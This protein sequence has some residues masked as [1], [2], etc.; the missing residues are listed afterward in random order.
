MN[1][2]RCIATLGVL[3]VVVTA[4][5]AQAIVAPI[6][7]EQSSRHSY[8]IRGSHLLLKKEAEVV[9]YL[10]Q[11]PEE[12]RNQALKKL[13]AFNFTVGSTHTWYTVDYTTLNN[14]Q[15]SS[16]CRAVGTNCYIFVE[17][18]SWTGGKVTQAAVDSVR[19]AFDQQ[20]PA[21]A[22]RGIYQTNVDAFG[23]PPNVDSDLRIVILILDIR[24]TY[25]QTQTGGYV[26]GYFYSFNETNQA[27]SN[28]AEILF[29]DCNPTDLTQ[30]WGVRDAMSTVAHEFQHMIHFNYIK[31]Q[32]TFI[33]EGFSLVAEVNAGYPIYDQ[34]DFINEPNHYLFEWL[35]VSDP[36]VYNDYSRAARFAVY[37]R[38]QFSMSYF[39]NV[40]A[41]GTVGVAGLNSGFER[42]GTP[43]RFIDVLK[44]WFI[45]NMVND[46]SIDTVWGYLY[47]N[48]SQVIPQVFY[49][50]N[51]TLQTGTVQN[52]AA[53]YIAFKKG[54]NLQVTFTTPSSNGVAMSIKALEIGPSSKRVLNVT[55][56][57]QFSEPTFGTTYT[58]IY[59]IISNPDY[60]I[61]QSYTLQSSGNAVAIEQRWDDN[62]EPSGYYVLNTSDT[63]C[64][65]FDAVA[66]GR[67]D[68]LRVALRRAG[69]ITGGIFEYTGNTPRPTPNGR[70]LAPFTAT[71]IIDPEPPTPYPVPWTNWVTVDLRSLN[72]PSDKALSVAFI[73]G[74]NPSAP[75]VMVTRKAIAGPYNNYVYLHE[76]SS[77]SPNWYFYA[78]TTNDTIP[79]FLVHSYFSFP[80]SV[81]PGNTNNDSIVDVRDVL[82]IG[83]YYG[84]TG[85]PRS[86]AT[87][88]WK[89]QFI[90]Q[91]WTP[92]NAGYADC[93]GNGVVDS[94]DVIAIIQNW[95]A[96]KAGGVPSGL[97][98][99]AVCTELLQSID[100]NAAGGPMLSIR[101]AIV[102]YMN[103]TLIEPAQNFPAH[104]ELLQ[105][106]PNPFNPS[107]VIRY[108]LPKHMDELRISIF[109]ILGQLVWEKSIQD[110]GAGQHEM[111]WFGETMNGVKVGTGVY[112]YRISAGSF[113]DVKKM[114]LIK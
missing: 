53:D 11:H 91:S 77:G 1:I 105:N 112:I 62:T 12:L 111:Q 71:S 13:N 81:Y 31:G 63:I 69:S 73:V 67:M 23:N 26:G 108:N 80:Q 14:V 4:I 46:R 96:T 6:A 52:L 9:A 37:L 34:G 104:F 22:S 60:G 18:A 49:N 98:R 92:V 83:L 93:N 15:V 106:F 78:N 65:A 95:Y 68:S 86:G 45:A 66:G 41:S 36:G 57:V 42:I 107:T 110:I 100:R 44:N 54:S 88:T 82:P 8:P 84:K 38:D 51:I 103:Q 25:S 102:A 99:S 30:S 87:T 58:E 94:N 3:I 101:N 90:G 61:Q 113:V 89:K 74:T 70:L 10:K 20:T 50:P 28:Q 19:I 43:F 16:T 79:I 76:P 72:V 17:D 33:N 109:N 48:I 32:Q 5:Q 24:D 7:K 85:P 27:E 56:G 2:Y 39:K 75:G 35:D 114:I 64:V 97:V 55:P 29:I 21:N 59:F 47:P 40:L